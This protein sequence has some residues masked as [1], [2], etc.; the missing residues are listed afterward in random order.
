MHGSSFTDH[1]FEDKSRQQGLSAGRD[2]WSRC[3][4]ASLLVEWRVEGFVINTDVGVT[5]SSLV[6]VGVGEVHKVSRV[7]A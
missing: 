3:H 7:H 1:A 4:H 6:L 5:F 2:S